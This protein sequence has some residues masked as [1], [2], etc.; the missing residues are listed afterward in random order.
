MQERIICFLDV[1]SHYKFSQNC[2]KITADDLS[3]LE[4]TVK[5]TYSLCFCLL[6]GW[7]FSAFLDIKT[8]P[9]R[10]SSDLIGTA[11]AE[12]MQ[13]CLGSNRGKR[14]SRAVENR[15]A[16]GHAGFPYD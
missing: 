7:R 14:I 8:A 1:S 2:L 10:K 13:D 12:A 16:C 3:N 9:P 15:L 5:V 4:A 11:E 6:G